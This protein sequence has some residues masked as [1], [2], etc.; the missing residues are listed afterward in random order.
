RDITDLQSAALAIWLRRLKNPLDASYRQ[1][2]QKTSHLHRIPETQPYQY[3]EKILFGKQC[4]PHKWIRRKTAAP[5][6]L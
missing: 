1:I 5:H 2:R 6:G 4:I 3:T